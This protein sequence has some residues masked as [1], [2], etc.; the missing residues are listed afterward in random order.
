MGKTGALSV[1]PADECRMRR[2]TDAMSNPNITWARNTLPQFEE[3]YAAVEQMSLEAGA[4]GDSVK[5]TGSLETVAPSV[6][7]ARERVARATAGLRTCPRPPDDATAQASSAMLAALD[8][9]ANAE[10]F[11]AWIAAWI[12]AM[13]D[14]DRFAHALAVATG[15]RPP[16]A[17]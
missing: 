5:E 14:N 9:F 17:R 2:H 11:D 3:F 8:D 16:V 7:V 12:K 1:V 4:A 10:R 15:Q 13:E 6:D